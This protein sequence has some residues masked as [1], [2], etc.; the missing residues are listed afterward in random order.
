MK[1]GYQ[2][3]VRTSFYRHRLKYK[4]LYTDVEFHNKWNILPS[5]NN[6]ELL[7][8]VDNFY[9]YFELFLKNIYF[10]GHLSDVSKCELYK[11]IRTKFI[12]N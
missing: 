2:K 6:C 7:N 3:W 11:Y 1:M 5:L 9:G 12:L 8:T 10:W 4:M